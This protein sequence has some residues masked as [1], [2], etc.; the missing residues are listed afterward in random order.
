MTVDTVQTYRS[1]RGGNGHNGAARKKSAMVIAI[2]N[3]KGGVAK[4]TTCLSL[5]GALAELGYSVLLMDLD[6]QASLTLSLGLNPAQVRHTA[7][8][9]LLGHHSLVGVSRESAQ[10]ALDIVPAS[11]E[12]IVLDSLTHDKPEE[13]L[14]LRRKLD[15]YVKNIYNFVLVDCPPSG[16]NLTLN[17]L[18]AA[19]LLIIPVQ[20]EFYAAH[21]LRQTLK[22]VQ[23]VREEH[24]VHLKWRILITLYDMRNKICRLIRDQL[25]GALNTMLFDTIIQI[26]TK[27][28]ESPVYGKP[29]TAYAPRSRGAEQYRA[30]AAELLALPEPT[31]GH[32]NGR[33]RAVTWS[34]EAIESPADDLDLEISPA[35]LAL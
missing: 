13:Q 27:L 8:D 33:T 16:G 5:G 15:I 26:D 20:C 19:D 9:T 32:G 3:Q 34:H 6:P 21:S 17:A 10:F 1:A 30:L 18:A 31:N 14:R 23:R 24:G 25:H 2:A 22:L 35:A 7:L 12:L 29:I 4:T 11:R 28:R